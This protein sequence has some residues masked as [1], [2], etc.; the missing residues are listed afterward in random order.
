MSDNDIYLQFISNYFDVFIHST[1][2]K[3]DANNYVQITGIL[4]AFYV[5][6]QVYYGIFIFNEAS[7]C[8]LRPYHIV[9]LIVTTLLQSLPNLC[10]FADIMLLLKL[11][12]IRKNSQ[13]FSLYSQLMDGSEYR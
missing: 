9:L 13:S 3:V 8:W 10:N 2:T 12:T 4:R 1:I 6:L 7:T 5:L 11:E